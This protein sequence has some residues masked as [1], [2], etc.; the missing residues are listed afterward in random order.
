MRAADASRRIGA[1]SKLTTAL[2]ALALTLQGLV[3]AA[4][5]R[6]EPVRDTL[7]FSSAFGRPSYS[8]G[9]ETA[10][11]LWIEG[12]RI[13]VRVTADGTPHRVEGELRTSE[14]GVFEDVAP[15]SARLR[16]RQPRPSKLM[17]DVSVT[18]REEGFDITLAGDYA[19]LAVD[20]LIDGR[21]VPEAVRIG[22]RAESPYS[23]PVR[24]RLRSA[25]ASWL[26]LG[27]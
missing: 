15:L 27:Q 19:H 8:S 20:L 4:V 12:G 13:H 21:R 6:A 17:F 11:F 10:C 24:L 9:H 18:D 5:T 25:R 16:P 1:G 23:L 14:Q 7:P 22:D 26:G 2:A 3:S